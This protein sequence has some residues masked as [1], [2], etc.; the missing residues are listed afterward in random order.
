MLPILLNDSLDRLV[1]D[2]GVAGRRLGNAID[3]LLHGARDVATLVQRSALPRRTVDRL[4]ALDADAAALAAV[5]DRIGM[6][7]AVPT[8]PTAEAVARM[9]VLIDAA[10]EPSRQLDHVSAT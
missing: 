7:P 2:L 10:P 9:Q 8:Q 3:A 4:I 1:A 5:R 6:Q